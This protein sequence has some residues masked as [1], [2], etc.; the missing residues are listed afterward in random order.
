MHKKRVGGRRN[1]GKNWAPLPQKPSPNA[2]CV[3]S[4]Q[5]TAEPPTWPVRCVL[6]M[7]PRNLLSPV[8]INRHSQILY[9]RCP[10]ILTDALPSK[11]HRLAH[12]SPSPGPSVSC[13]IHRSLLTVSACRLPGHR[14]PNCT[15]APG[16]PA[17]AYI[18]GPLT[19][20]T[21]VDTGCSHSNH[22]DACL[23]HAGP[24]PET[25]HHSS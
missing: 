12:A 11:P 21:A 23:D 24:Q 5:R 3:L 20:H 4:S 19:T 10:S 6:S 8:W 7:K 18:W 14:S 15:A 17:P 22:T 9:E 16:F 25:V 13:V 1:G 2:D